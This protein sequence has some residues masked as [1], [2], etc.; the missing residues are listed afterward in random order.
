M[1]TALKPAAEPP[2]ASLDA[3]SRVVLGEALETA[4]RQRRH[5]QERIEITG[6]TLAATLTDLAA[7]VA[8][9]RRTGGYMSHADQVALRSAEARLVAHGRS[10]ER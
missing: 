8:I 4:Q 9:V 1:V 5:L 6:A 2:P 10:V 7:L 3:L